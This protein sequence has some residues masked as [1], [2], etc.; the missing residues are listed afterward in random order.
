MKKAMTE[1]QRIRFRASWRK[2]YLAN[3]AK[4]IEWQERRRD[5]MR[6]WII[7]MKSVG[8][9]TCG[10]RHPGCLVF[11][12]RDPAT[13]EFSLGSA[14]AFSWSKARLEV[15]IAKCDVLCA[16][17]HAKLHARNGV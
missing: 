15:E 7:S 5:E 8:C 3:R 2:W 9:G 16:N 17:C 12:H 4:K 6:D 11:H 10:E 14:L 1:E 13:K